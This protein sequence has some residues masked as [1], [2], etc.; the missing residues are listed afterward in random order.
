MISGFEGEQK[1]KSSDTIKIRYLLRHSNQHHEFQILDKT[2]MTAIL[3]EDIAIE[4][5]M[6]VFRN[7]NAVDIKGRLKKISLEIE[8]EELAKITEALALHSV[9][10]GLNPFLKSP[11][12]EKLKLSW[13]AKI[14]SYDLFQLDVE[15]KN[16]GI[17]DAQRLIIMTKSSNDLLDGLEF[18]IGRLLPGKKEKR[19]LKINI[20][21][22][23]VDE[24]EPIEMIIFDHNL[25]KIKSIKDRLRF[26]EKPY[27]FF[28]VS[29]KIYDNGEFGS[30]G[31][32]D[33]KVQSGETIALSFKITNLS[34]KIIPKLMFNIKGTERSFR[35]NR[36][37]IVL[38]D[39]YPEIDQKD[40]FLFQMKR[41]S[42]RHNKI[43][44]EMN[45]KN[46]GV[47]KISKLWLLDKMLTDEQILT[48]VFVELKWHDLN[49]NNVEG[50]TQLETLML[51]GKI[52]NAS[53]VRDLYVH[54]NDKKVFYKAN[55]NHQNISR[56]QIENSMLFQ[57]K[58]II[59]LSP[60][61]NKISVFTRSR[62]GFTS[63]HKLRM[64][65][66]H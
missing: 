52:T 46:S 18:P 13:S 33:G 55:L 32:G 16:E 48:P 64:L 43:L 11:S 9:D 12:R 2:V 6:R 42:S 44:M 66:E 65:R 62:H 61:I 7:W 35:I 15:L 59:N 21:P 47:P 36:G 31:N 54:L 24:T 56:Y 4:T 26:P 60:G 10:W 25:K 14:I 17:I 3:K 19:S 8:N 40:F 57:F 34:K 63:E 53:E 5:A 37:K 22:E 30:E 58:K 39:L 29:M 28:K 41:N 49:G 20:S 51:S 27:T 50:E 1:N 23:M 38:T 45:A